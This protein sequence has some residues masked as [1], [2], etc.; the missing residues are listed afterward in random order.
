[1]N[2]LLVPGYFDIALRD[3]GLS[4]GSLALALLSVTYGL[5]RFF[6]A[7]TKWIR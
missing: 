5:N 7:G 1:M 6:A 2:L 3:F 4:L